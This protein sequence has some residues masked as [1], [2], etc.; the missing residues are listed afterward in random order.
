ML[1]PGERLILLLMEQEGFIVKFK[2]ILKKPSIVV[3][4][5]A[6][7]FAIF[8]V[9]GCRDFSGR[10]ASPEVVLTSDFQKTLPIDSSAQWFSELHNAR[11]VHHYYKKRNFLATWL[12]DSLPAPQ[13]DSLIEFIRNIR[14]YGLRPQHYH[15]HEL[16]KSMMDSSFKDQRMKHRM[17]LLLTDAFISLACDIRHGRLHTHQDSTVVEHVDS[18]S[19]AL[20][21]T[22]FSDNALSSSL[23]NQQP[24]HPQYKYLRD[25]LQRLISNADDHRRNQLLYGHQPDSLAT[26]DTL[27]LLE[28]NM[29]RWREERSPMRQSILVNIPAYY[30]EILQDDSIV[31]E[32]KVIVGSAKNKTPLLDGVLRSF[33]IFPYW[34]VPRSIAVNEILP[35]AKKDSMYLQSHHYDILDVNETILDPMTVPWNDLSK[36]NFPYT[37]RQ[38]EGMHNALGLVKFWFQNPYDVYLHD[39]NARYLFAKEKRAMSHGCVRVHKAMELARHLL[40]GDDVVSP[41]D[42]DQYIEMQQQTRIKVPTP[43]DVRFRYFT[44][45]YMEGVVKYFDDVYGYDEEYLKSMSDDLTPKIDNNVALISSVLK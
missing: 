14:M 10:T 39:T 11:A 42:L 32:S 9:M 17:E 2:S 21:E 23:R 1:S 36:N 34:N 41:E 5:L 4:T 19:I 12:N 6:V 28:L 31:F 29:Q 16:N 27:R 20:L 3:K 38:K 13:A 37:I 22:A 15:Y 43:I 44:A 26:R 24:A 40:E 33:M 35:Q 18:T 7:V 8:Q 25:E 30:L 45:A